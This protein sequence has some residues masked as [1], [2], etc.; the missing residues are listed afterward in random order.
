[1]D[2]NAALE[3]RVSAPGTFMLNRRL[4]ELPDVERSFC[5]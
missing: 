3:L 2:L 1:M 5:G 4:N